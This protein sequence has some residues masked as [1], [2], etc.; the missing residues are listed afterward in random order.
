MPFLRRR[1]LCLLQPHRYLNVSVLGQVQIA[2]D[3]LRDHLHDGLKHAADR[4]GLKRQTRYVLA[5][6]HEYVGFLAPKNINA[7]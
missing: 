7:V 4:V 1:L 5:C 2:L 6:R 3:Q